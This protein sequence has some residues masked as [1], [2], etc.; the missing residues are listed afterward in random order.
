[1]G[2]K[3]NIIFFIITIF[4]LFL[5][6]SM[7]YLGTIIYRT[8]L[9]QQKLDFNWKYM[10]YTFHPEL[11]FGHIPGSRTKLLNI[12]IC[13]DENGFRIPKDKKYTEKRPLILALGGSFTFGDMC[14]AENTFPFLVGKY[15]GGST[16][17]GGGCSYGLSQMLILARKLI[18]E[19]KPDIVLVQYSPWLV[20]RSITPF[21][22]STFCIL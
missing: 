21:G 17:N 6:F 8:A 22:T 19:Y 9:L 10:G 18:P 11:G 15:L 20:D 5:L 14:F 2:K 16:V 3:K 4:L 7:L 1:M 12:P 13:Y